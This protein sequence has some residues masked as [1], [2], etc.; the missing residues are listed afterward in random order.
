MYKFRQ[1]LKNSK[2]VYRL[3]G[4][5]RVFI[6]KIR[7]LFLFQP[8]KFKKIK[9][10]KNGKSCFIVATGPSLSL[11]DLNL[12]KGQFSFGCNSIL[13]CFDKTTWRPDFYCISDI[14]IFNKYSKEMLMH[15]LNKIFIPLDFKSDLKNKNI[16]F[17]S[18][19]FTQHIKAI[20]KNNF[21]KIIIPSKHMDKYITDATSVIFICIQI[22]VYMGFKNIY[23]LGQDCNYG[24]QAKHSNIA[25]YNDTSSVDSKIGNTML[26]VFENYKNF[27]NNKGIN[28]YNCTRGGL[29][30][31]F[32]RIKLEEAIR[33]TSNN[34]SIKNKRNH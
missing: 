11:N 23:L 15:D 25:N 18:R 10:I 29:L 6:N 16:Y 30:E 1:K 2:I 4:A 31:A 12:L 5:I 26:D 27:Y 19:S 9:N 33:K 3:Y 7:D 20:Y 17:Y 13:N 34:G 28:I 14:N 8:R 22:A 24:G 32:P 21:N